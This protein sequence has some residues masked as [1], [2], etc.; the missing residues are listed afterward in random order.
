VLG[1]VVG[2]L[3]ISSLASVYL[4]SGH[5]SSLG[6]V[7]GAVVVLLLIP[8]LAAVCMISSYTSSLGLMLGVVLALL[9]ISSFA[10]VCSGFGQKISPGLVL[11]TSLPLVPQVLNAPLVVA[12]SSNSVRAP[13]VGVDLLFVDVEVVAVYVLI[14]VLVVASSVGSVCALAI[15]TC[16]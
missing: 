14:S 12:S 7:L 16:P 6:S 10:V 8:P 9:Q 1:V 5:A 15:F 11:N 3:L 2:L 4:I 13:A